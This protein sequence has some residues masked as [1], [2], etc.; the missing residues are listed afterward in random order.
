[1]FRVC[2][3][4]GAIGIL[5]F[6]SSCE[7]DK[8]EAYLYDKPGFDSGMMPKDPNPNLPTRV[9]PNYYQPQP[10]PYQAPQQNYQQQILPPGSRFYSN[11]YAIPPAEYYPPQYDVDQYYV[12]PT[13]SNNIEPPMVQPQAEERPRSRGTFF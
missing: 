8:R 1:M 12:P 13:Y 7:R 5:I 2:F 6:T 9:V 10:Y 3:L 4:L 11:P